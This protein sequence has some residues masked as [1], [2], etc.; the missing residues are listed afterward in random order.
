MERKL[1]CIIHPCC[2][3]TTKGSSEQE[4][5]IHTEEFQRHQILS[6]CKNYTSDK[7]QML[8]VFHFSYCSLFFWPVVWKIQIKKTSSQQFSPILISRMYRHKNTGWKSFTFIPIWRQQRPPTVCCSRRED[9]NRAEKTHI[10]AGGRTRTATDDK[11]LCFQ[12]SDPLT[13]QPTGGDTCDARAENAKLW[14]H[15]SSELRSGAFDTRRTHRKTVD[16]LFL[17]T[18]Q[19]PSHN[20]E[21]SQPP[22]DLA[23]TFLGCDR[24][25]EGPR[26]MGS[27]TTTQEVYNNY[28]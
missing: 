17:D 26:E 24:K 5:W 19:S 27:T 8:Q 23:C 20:S 13:A 4:A 12:R 15:K 7:W 9:G 28:N 25:Q 11:A 3:H 6:S 22:S 1:Q 18:R 10:T 21:Q 14:Y 2:P 16:R